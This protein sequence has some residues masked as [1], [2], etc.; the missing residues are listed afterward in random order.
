MSN[1]YKQLCDPPKHRQISE[2]ELRDF[3]KSQPNEPICSLCEKTSG[4]DC[5]CHIYSCPCNKLAT[6]CI[7]PSCLCDS[8]LKFP[9][10]CV[11][12]TNER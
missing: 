2:S 11:C 9:A 7:W 10:C 3:T 12:N 8:C 5:R 1:K 4:I 6:K